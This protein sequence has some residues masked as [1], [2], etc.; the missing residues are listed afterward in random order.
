MI[1][2]K[3]RVSRAGG[4]Y[5][6]VHLRVVGVVGARVPATE[7]AER[8]VVDGREEE[9]EAVDEPRSGEVGEDYG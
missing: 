8:R 4:S 9:D 1:Q 5:P 7:H 2:S 6:L 3:L